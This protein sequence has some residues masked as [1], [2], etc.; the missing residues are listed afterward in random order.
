MFARWF[1][2]SWMAQ[3]VLAA[4]VWLMAIPAW[5]GYS[6]NG[7]D[8]GLVESQS[9]LANAAVSVQTNPLWT[10]TTGM[11]GTAVSTTFTL[12]QHDGVD[13]GRLYLDVYGGNPY[14]TAQIT[15]SLNGIALPTLS[16]G[17]TGY[18]TDVNPATRDPNTTCVYGSGFAFWEI[19][20]A[21]VDSLL[22]G[23][24]AV[25]TL[26]F[27]VNN[28]S[29]VGGGQDEMQSKF[30]GR[31]YGA[32]LVAAY[33]DP[34]LNQTLDYQLFEGGATMRQTTSTTPPY[35]VKNLD[36]A[37]AISGVNVTNLGMATYTASY[38]GGHSGQYDQVYF[39][40]T[41]LG[42]S[43]GLGNDIARGG[44]AT[45][46]RSFNVTGYLTSSNSVHYTI[47]GVFMGTGTGESTY[48]PDFGLLTVTHPV[49]EPSTLALLAAGA[50]GLLVLTR[51]L[52]I[53]LFFRERAG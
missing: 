51:F 38:A 12:P 53:P 39:N 44:Y 33:T 2:N 8:F 19:A 4:A 31:V 42:T 25:N 27:T 13:F 11:L 17:G 1:S 16:I 3:T 21:N 26:T 20:Y 48:Y 32:T 52:P 29:V 47:D 6:V 15:A 40:G 41:A 14:N 36:R 37:F 43:A 10:A 46:L 5:A 9:G 23:G 28:T 30:D 50:G 18:L 45:E 35:P 24:T 22:K 49:P 7:Y 34:S